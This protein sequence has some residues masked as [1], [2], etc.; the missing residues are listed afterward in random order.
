[1]KVTQYNKDGKDETSDLTGYSFT[2]NNNGTISAA[3]GSSTS[4]G[5]WV[6]GTD[7]SLD[8]LYINFIGGGNLEKMNED[9]HIL[10]KT[11]TLIRLQHISG[12]S[13]E[14]ENLT[15]SKN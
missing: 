1:M 6:G 3:K 13:G 11:T 8:K 7:D 2:F 12:G 15:M 5:S 10:E 4:T 14:T 9:L